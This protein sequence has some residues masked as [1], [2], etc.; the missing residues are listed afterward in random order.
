MEK[1]LLLVL[2]SETV[3]FKQIC[4]TG[5]W[6]MVASMNPGILVY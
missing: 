1:V 2:V 6:N 4:V 5:V 3:S